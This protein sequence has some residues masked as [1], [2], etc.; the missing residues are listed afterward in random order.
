MNKFDPNINLISSN[1]VFIG[2]VTRSGKGFLCPIASSFEKFEMFF[3]SSVAENISYMDSLKKIDSKFSSFLIKLVFNEIIYNMNIGRNLNQRKTDYTSVTKFRDP[4]M[5]QRRM[6][7]IEGDMVIKRILKEKNSYPV[8]FH[9]PLINPEILL[10]SFPNAK[11]IFLDRHPLELVEEWMNK[12]YSGDIYDNPRNVI[13]SMK[14]KDKNYPYWVKTKVD[15]INKGK[16]MYIKTIYSL[17][18]LLFQQKK[19]LSNLDKKLKKRVLLVKFDPLIQNTDYE[20]KKIT[21]FLK[22][23]ISKHTSAV[24]LKERGNRKID[25]ER[26]EKKRNKLLK[27][28]DKETTKLFKKLEAS[29][30]N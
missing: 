7:G 2:G 5:Y 27:L 30:Y 17:S 20:I 23:K 28:L 11:I 1:L 19:V 25:F 22:C 6:M 10:N 8:M 29:Y 26:R 14:Y 15:K 13:L 3:M 4:K 16:N 9:D 18:E 21:K 12:K 24:I